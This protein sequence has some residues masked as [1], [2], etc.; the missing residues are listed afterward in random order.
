M[1]LR[2]LRSAGIQCAGG[3]APK[4]HDRKHGC[5]ACGLYHHSNG[6]PLSE[7]CSQEQFLTTEWG[8]HGF[9]SQ[10]KY[11]PPFYGLPGI[12][13]GLGNIGRKVLHTAFRDKYCCLYFKGVMPVIF[14]KCRKKFE[15]LWKPH[16]KQMTSVVSLS[17]MSKRQAWL[18]LISVRNSL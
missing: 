5:N 6:L 4:I 11:G 2:K 10:V 12:K 16:S 17:S 1:A 8:C 18:I 13:E 3:K 14:L 15:I 7:G 9:W